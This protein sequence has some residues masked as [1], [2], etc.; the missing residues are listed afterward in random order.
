MGLFGENEDKEK[1]AF[2]EAIKDVN[3]DA[4]ILKKTLLKNETQLVD[5]QN[6]FAIKNTRKFFLRTLDIT[7][8]IIGQSTF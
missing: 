4:S 3:K 6:A 5:L 8:T 1:I 2:E 7:S